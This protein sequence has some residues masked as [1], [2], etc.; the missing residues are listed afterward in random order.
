M[1]AVRLRLVQPLPVDRGRLCGE[2]T[3]R[4]RHGDLVAGQLRPV[5]PRDAVDEMALRHARRLPAPVHGHRFGRHHTGKGAGVQTFLPYPD[6][7]A[8]ARVLDPRRLGNQRSEALVV[9]RVC[10]IQTYGWQHHPVVRMWRGHE[11][12]LMAYG[13]AICEEWTARGHADTVIAKLA[14]WAPQARLPTQEELVERGALP[15]WL[16]DERLHQSHRSAL[17][18]KDPAWYRPRFPDV[19]DD[20]PYFWPV[21]DA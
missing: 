15:P 2:T 17:V 20:L 1:L 5:P 10:R 4:R 11:P 12:A 7:R 3:L 19:P 16:G 8:A 14:E 9:L 13:R 6:F 21:P 18:R